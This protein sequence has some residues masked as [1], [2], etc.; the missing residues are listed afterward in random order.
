[1][2]YYSIISNNLF[3][4]KEDAGL[5]KSFND[6]LL[7]VC[8]YLYTNTNRQDISIF[9]LSDI[10]STYNFKDNYRT[11]SQFKNIFIEMVN[12]KYITILSKDKDNKIIDVNNIKLNDIIRC[13]FNLLEKKDNKYIKFIQ[14]F[15]DEK[16]KI[17]NYK[18]A[19]NKVDN[20]KL[21]VY[22][23]YLKCRMY[24][25]SNEDGDMIE[26]GGKAETCY[27]SFKRI[28]N[29]INITE[30]AIKKYNDI[31]IKLDLIRVGNAGLYYFK[32]DSNKKL[33]E[34]NNVYTLLIDNDEETAQNNLKESVKLYKLE[35]KED[36]VFV[37]KKHYSINNRKINGYKGRIKYLINN[38]KATTEQIQQYNEILKNE[39]NI[40]I[41]NDDN[42]DVEF[43]DANVVKSLGIPKDEFFNPLNDWLEEMPEEEDDYY[44]NNNNQNDDI[45][46]YDMF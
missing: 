12:K 9:S 15:D 34:S 31:L 38:N 25:R 33:Y 20:V 18:D 11:N 32:S 39:K 4:I 7:L 37:N 26:F 5:I 35:H 45:D 14:L 44:N 27:P 43:D 23:C 36:R 46:D 30:N 42:D 29:D 10:V 17:L 1:M 41:V 8:D 19:D 16:Q 40:N 2:S 6:K 24:K 21:L 22:Y 13:K 3:Y 28:A